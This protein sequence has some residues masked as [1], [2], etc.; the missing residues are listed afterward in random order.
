MV[1]ELPPY[2]PSPRRRAAPPPAARLAFHDR[3]DGARDEG[4]RSIFTAPT[5]GRDFRMLLSNGWRV[6][7]SYPH[8]AKGKRPH[9][10][11]NVPGLKVP[12]PGTYDLAALPDDAIIATHWAPFPEDQ[13]EDVA[14]RILATLT[15]LYGECDAS[16]WLLSE[17]QLLGGMV[18]DDLLRTGEGALVLDL[19][20]SL[21][22]DDDFL[23]A[24]D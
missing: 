19:V 3:M 16:R 10:I 4:W 21:C 7:A 6:T 24:Y 14:A 13:R 11:V 17:Q 5:D 20:L 12:I 8:G 1:E 15:R 18:P 2:A 22:D 9:W 23:S